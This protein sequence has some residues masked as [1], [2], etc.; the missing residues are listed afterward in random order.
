MSQ[1]RKE[2]L[3]GID[4]KQQSTPN[5]KQSSRIKKEAFKKA[6]V[7]DKNKELERRIW[8]LEKSSTISRAQVLGIDL[9][10]TEEQNVK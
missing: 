10:K 2:G 1:L 8:Y 4:I 3:K 6:L 5:Q 9:G 7:I